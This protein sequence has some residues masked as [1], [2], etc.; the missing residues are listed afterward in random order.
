MSDE[1]RR[2]RRRTR[3]HIIADLGV[4][5]V[6]RQILLT[7][8]T[9]ERYRYDYGI[10][11]VMKTYDPQGHVEGGSVAFQIKATDHFAPHA[12]GLTVSIRVDLGHLKGWLLEWTPVILI[13]FDASSDRAY[14]LNIQEYARQQ[15]LDTDAAGSTVSLAIPLSNLFNPAAVLQLREVK[16]QSNPPLPPMA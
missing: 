2:L 14:W 16:E 13:L 4:N 3:E 9:V 10:D 8:F 6:E 5:Y 1:Q 7:G 11:L 12:D 15:D